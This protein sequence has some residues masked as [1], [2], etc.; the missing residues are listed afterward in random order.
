EARWLFN[1]SQENIEV[2][3]H[4]QSIIHSMVQFS[5]GSVIAQLGQP[6]MRIPIQYALAYP[7]RLDL[8][9]DRLNFAQLKEFTFFNPDLE[10]FPCL[11]LAYKAL[12][13]GGNMPCIMNAANEIAVAA[14]LRNDIKFGQIPEIIEETMSLCQFDNTPDIEIIYKTNTEAIQV[15]SQLIKKI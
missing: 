13:K 8:N 15:A 5:D 6:D 2:V 4:P 1:I 9:T 3:I 7:Y 10:R 12:E 14:F 11:G